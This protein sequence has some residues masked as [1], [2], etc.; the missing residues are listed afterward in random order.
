MEK[1]LV[2]I[3]IPCYNGEK[4]LFRL[5]ESLFMQTYKKQQIIFV[6]DGST[7][8]TE[9]IALQ[10]K[11]YFECQGIE[12]LYLYQK[13]SGQAAAINNALCH[14]N[15]EYCMW[16]DADDY[17]TADHIESKVVFLSKHPEY[18]LVM[19][20]GYVVK[21]ENPDKVTAEL[22]HEKAVGTLFE[23][24]IFERRRC[25]PGLY[26]VRTK[27]LLSCLKEKKIYESAAGQN[28]Q[29]LL[30]TA[31]SEKNGF[32]DRHLFYYVF[33][34][35]SHS[36]AFH[37]S[38][39]YI[40]RFEDL[41]RVKLYVINELDLKDEYK[42]QLLHYVKLH[43]VTKKIQQLGKNINLEN[44]VYINKLKTDYLKLSDVSRY[45][46]G[47]ALFLWGAC[48]ISGQI[49]KILE[50][51]SEYCIKG[52]IDSD[53]DKVGL[54]INDIEVY[55]MDSIDPGK[56]YLLIPLKVH[57]S[58]LKKLQEKNF[59]LKNDFFYPNLELELFLK[60]EKYAD[61]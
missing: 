10:Y 13:N 52:Y 47:R 60:G 31:L 56:M 26:M 15:G 29:L 16:F 11:K 7:D 1:G 59:V 43:M 12:F 39:E 8:E 41:E 57:H 35:D 36:R 20:K 40:K 9:K 14:L 6:N 55:D 19:C 28:I 4:F 50:I 46:K 22:G 58:I 38:E 18:D 42:K 25:T 23:D 5:F 3:M 48:Q 33:R 53:K 17:M 61:C 21:E 32:L 24:I 51:T 27:R 34:E 30:P 45:L 2:S 49:R 54:K 44:F 37:N